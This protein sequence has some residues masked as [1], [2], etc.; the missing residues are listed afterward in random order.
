MVGETMDRIM[1]SVLHWLA[2]VLK[3]GQFRSAYVISVFRKIN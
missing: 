1:A 2:A 3:F